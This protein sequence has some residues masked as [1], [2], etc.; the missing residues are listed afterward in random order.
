LRL[1]AAVK[2]SGTGHCL[3]HRNPKRKRTSLYAF[4][5][6]RRI[7]LQALFFPAKFNDKDYMFYKGGGE[8]YI[9]VSIECYSLIRT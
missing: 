1:W 5:T 3:L 2:D 4:Y 6:K 8:T 9:E 7:T